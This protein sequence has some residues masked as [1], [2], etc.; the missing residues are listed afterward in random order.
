MTYWSLTLCEATS[1]LAGTLGLDGG[2]TNTPHPSEAEKKGKKVMSS[3]EGQ[4][5]TDLT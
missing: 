2:Q 1:Q 4:I 5:V 3:E